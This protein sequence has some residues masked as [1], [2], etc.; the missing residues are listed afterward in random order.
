MS[1]IRKQ[2]SD[3]RAHLRIVK[4]MEDDPAYRQ[5]RNKHHSPQRDLDIVLTLLL[6]V[7]PVFVVVF[8]VWMVCEFVAGWPK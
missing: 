5:G 4:R 6:T 8:G 7:G 3:A 1:T 2:E